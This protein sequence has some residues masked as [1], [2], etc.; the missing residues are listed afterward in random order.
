[1]GVDDDA[2]VVVVAAA[3]S[4]V[5]GVD[6]DNRHKWEPLGVVGFEK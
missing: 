3:G 2:A 1:M 5:A 4:V 6:I